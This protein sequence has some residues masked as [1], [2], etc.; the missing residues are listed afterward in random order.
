MQLD[1]LLRPERTAIV[2]ASE[3]EG[4]GGDTCRNVLSYTDP[5]KVYFIN[6]KRDEIFGRQCWPSL[7]ALPKNI[8]Q[9]VIC[10]PQKTV[11][12]LLRE[13]A[14]KGAK[15]AV[16]YASGYKETGTK[17]GEQAEKELIALCRE[18]G[19]SLMGP[20]CAGFLNFNDHIA[21][22]A[23]ISEVRD[24]SGKVGFASQSGQLCL[25]AMD[26]PN[27]RLSYAISGGNCS[28]TSMEDYLEFLVNDPSTSVVALYLEGVK[29]PAK[30]VASLQKAAAIKKPVVVLKVGRSVK[31][32]ATAA[33]HTG[34]L[35]GADATFDAV[36][37][38]F[39]VIRVDDLQELLSTSLTLA[40]WNGLPQSAG[41]A[42]MSLS[43][44]ETGICAD[45]GETT[46]LAYPD[47]T[48]K[49]LQSLREQLPSYATPRNPLDMTASLS[50]EA[51]KFAKAVRTV[52]DDPGVGIVLIG[53]TLLYEIGDPAIH[54]MAAGMEQVVKEGGK[55]KPMVMMP[56]AENSRNPEYLD[57]LT[58]IGVP[59]LPPPVYGLKI[60][61]YITDYVDYLQK[62]HTLKL[63]LSGERAEGAARRVLTEF[64]SMG[65]LKEYGI[66]VPAG[67]LAANAASVVDMASKMGLGAVAGG[68]KVVLKI[69]SAD[70]P[71][72]TDAGGVRLNLETLEQV[73]EAFASIMASCRAYTP[74]AKLDGVFVQ[75]MLP[76][77]LEVIIGVN[78][79]PQFGPQ[80]LCGLG[81]IFVEIFKDTALYPAPMSK[82]EALDMLKSLKAYPLLAGYRGSKSLDLDALAETIVA[83]GDF[84]VAH[85]KAG[86]P[87]LT[88][89]D[90]NPLFV[91]E[92]G[93][94]A[95]D[96]LVVLEG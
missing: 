32:S 6:P 76:K 47:F 30:L 18:L 29:N 26:T 1:K 78:N 7:A 28:V 57:K 64:E 66:P 86:A 45:V 54:Y 44:G 49:T 73:A 92:K 72:K 88:E 52:M 93:V 71:H 11:N 13:A 34:S 37:K 58:A 16:V 22:F 61:K 21:S 70:I 56:F 67:A 4:F 39:G 94:C 24:R 48:E 35:S 77:G 81:G 2:G 41:V 42:S 31:G 17:E 46:G 79:D 60:I 75:Q 15:S 36:F 55:L 96:A 40:T 89:L 38:K 63:A 68:K 50:Y 19:M 12:G 80:V 95:A 82:A 83:V 14:A 62:T 33:S 53:Y 69:A 85:N 87:R 25:S 9:V 23:F 74:H 8:D 3:K 43:G 51:D 10:T 91:Y 84:A 65:L 27:M 59:V 5:D 90:I 20:N